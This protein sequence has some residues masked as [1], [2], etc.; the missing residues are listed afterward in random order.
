MVLDFFEGKI[1]EHLI[2]HSKTLSMKLWESLL[3]GLYLMWL[4]LEGT[5]YVSWENCASY[6]YV[7][8]IMK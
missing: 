6:R 2:L 1:P 4:N 5:Y 7:K 8:V 3:S